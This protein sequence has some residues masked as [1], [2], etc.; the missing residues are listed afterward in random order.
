[1]QSPK[2]SQASGASD[3]FNSLIIS[4]HSTLG[5]LYW[6]L[7]YS[8]MRRH[9]LRHPKTIIDYHRVIIDYHGISTSH[10]VQVVQGLDSESEDDEL[11]QLAEAMRQVKAQELFSRRFLRLR[12]CHAHSWPFNDF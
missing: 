10:S 6:I 8:R 3:C 9:S 2:E 1:M 12:A 4:S 11:V 7:G 5:E